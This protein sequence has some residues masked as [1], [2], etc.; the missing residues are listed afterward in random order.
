MSS[1]RNSARRLFTAEEIGSAARR[2]GAVS[3][4]LKERRR[5]ETRRL[6][7]AERAADF[8]A[9]QRVLARFVE[10]GDRYRAWHAKIKN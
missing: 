1:E 5:E 2:P 10:A 8:H 6:G 4:W 3:D 9:H 7:P